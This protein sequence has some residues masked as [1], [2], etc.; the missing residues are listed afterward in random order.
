MRKLSYSLLI[1][2]LL[3][4]CSPKK[5]ENAF[6]KPH[7][8]NSQ[9]QCH[10]NNALG[11]FD[12]L[13]NVNAVVTEQEFTISVKTDSKHENIEVKGFLEG[14]DMFMGKIPLF[15]NNSQKQTFTSKVMLGSCTEEYMVW[16]M[17]LIITDKNNTEN[18]TKFYIDFTSKRS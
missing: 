8:L 1:L 14:K 15:F 16:R 17:W 2:L 13:F 18:N 4:G 12:I 7:C 3:C 9:S 11:S 5:K 10:V 6:V